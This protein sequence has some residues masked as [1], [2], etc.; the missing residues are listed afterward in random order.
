MSRQTAG[1]LS[2]I[3]SSGALQ[4]LKEQGMAVKQEVGA[5]G[6]QTMSVI[7]PRSL[8]GQGGVIQRIEIEAALMEES[9]F[10]SWEVTDKNSP[11]GKSIIQGLSIDGA[12][13]I[14][15]NWGNCAVDALDITETPTSYLMPARFLDMETNFTATRIFISRKDRD[16][17][18]RYGD[19]R[20]Q[21]IQFAIGQSKAMRNVIKAC[22]PEYIVERA[23]K[24][25]QQN[26][27]TRIE[28]MVKKHTLAGVVKAAVE[29]LAQFEVTEAMILS[30]YR[31][32]AIGGIDID[33]LVGMQCDLRALEKGAETVDAL[34]IVTAPKSGDK[35]VEDDKRPP[36]SL[37]EMAENSGTSGL[38]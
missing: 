35:T 32:S 7:K 11:T 26:I 23:I 6:I 12:M 37:D 21:E 19:G 20:K 1:E 2:S 14:A 15:R 13:M 28:E 27:R 25:A 34:Y 5:G 17:G 33:D 18:G 38:F 3:P 24:A 4:S 8:A 29:K 16:T 10:Y 31:K 9:V 22:V 30:K 36:S